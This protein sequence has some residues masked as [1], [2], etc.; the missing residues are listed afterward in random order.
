[1]GEAQWFFMQNFRFEVTFMY[2]EIYV[3]STYFCSLLNFNFYSNTVY[4][5]LE[6]VYNIFCNFS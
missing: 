4:S 6:L 2:L 3:S 1:M 5:L